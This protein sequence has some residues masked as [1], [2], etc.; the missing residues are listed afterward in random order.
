[1]GA[2]YQRQL[3]ELEEE[4][5]RANLTNYVE[6][7]QKALSVMT[8]YNDRIVRA[9]DDLK[10]HF[11]WK[12]FTGVKEAAF[13]LM[14]YQKIIDTEGGGNAEEIASQVRFWQEKVIAAGGPGMKFDKQGNP[15]K[16]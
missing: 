16:G 6:K 8:E 2:L 3:A 7:Q 9:Y 5:C 4:G 14:K 12:R 15:K 10:T 1:M 13:Q 11:K